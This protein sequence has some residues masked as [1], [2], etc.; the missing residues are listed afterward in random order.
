MAEAKTPTHISKKTHDAVIVYVNSILSSYITSS[1]IRSQMLRRDV[2]YYRTGDLTQQQAL[3][4]AANDSGDASKMQNITVPV[5]MPQVESAVAYAAETF[6][7]GYPIFGVVAPPEEADAGMQMETLV[8]ENSIRAAWPAHL[9]QAFRDGYKYNL[10]AVEVVWDVRKIFNIVTPDLKNIGEGKREVTEY[11]GN[12]IKRLDP[13]NL[14]LDWRV[15]PAVNHIKGEVAGYSEIISRIVL[16]K[17]IEDLPPAGKMNIKDALSSPFGLAPYGNGDQTAAVFYPEVN[18]DALLPVANQTQGW[19]SWYA[20]QRHKPGNSDAISYS[21]CYERTILYARI[22][23]EDFDMGVDNRNQVQIWKFIIINRSV[24]IYAER[25]TNAHNMLPIV[26]C[27]PNDNGLGWQEK[28]LAENAM[29]FQALSSA[30]ANSGIESQRRKVYDRIFYDPTKIAKKDIDV[31]SSVARIPVKATQYGKGIA[32]AFAVVPYRDDGVAEIMNLVQ[33]F[34]DMADVANGQNRVQRGQFQKGNKTKSEFETVM[35]NSNSR[36]KIGSAI[37]ME[38][39]FITPIKQILLANYLQYQNPVRMVNSD[40][41]KPV[42]I[43]PTALRKAMVSFKMSDGV[44][45]TDKIMSADTL[46]MVFQSAQAMPEIRMQ[47]DLMGMFSYWMKL[48]GATWLND[49][50]YSPEQQQAQLAQMSQA[51]Q[52]SGQANP[53]PPAPPGAPDAGAQGAS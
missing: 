25:Q 38:Y 30:M 2:A 15:P 14:I 13:Y 36:Q 46:G 1:N 16:K 12:F 18:P 27:V 29:P 47:Y 45:P 33:V 48:K 22:I 8:G 11:A 39:G 23:P 24:I 4:K 34:S 41:K 53:P 10:G 50:K 21:D 40:T 37:V 31:T 20:G 19:L 28:S 17:E 51:S 32:D 35:N 6:L 42:D 26:C 5:V 49:F 43:D 3:A 9:T 52:A 7:T 44:L